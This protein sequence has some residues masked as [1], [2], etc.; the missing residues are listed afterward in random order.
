ME[1]QKNTTLPIISSAPGKVIL[2]G[3][4]A[5]VHGKLAIASSLGLRV[6][7]LLQKTNVEKEVILQLNDVKV[8]CRW[9]KEQL[10][11]LYQHEFIRSLDGMIQRSCLT[12]LVQKPST[13]PDFLEKLKSLIPEDQKIQVSAEGRGILVFLFLY[14]VASS[15]QQAKDKQFGLKV[16]VKSSLPIGM[17][18]GSSGTNE[19]IFFV[20]RKAL[21]AFVSPMDFLLPMAFTQ[22][23]TNRPILFGSQ[24]K[25]RKSL[26]M[27]GLSKL[28]K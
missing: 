14:F 4:H 2:F 7:A 17:G 26:S 6:R 23:I 27:A 19:L 8:R 1:K 5:V 20:K 3:E 18:L 25:L 11:P 9:T 13:S 15:S 10:E 12:I 16:S 24:A 21:L 22:T 28:R